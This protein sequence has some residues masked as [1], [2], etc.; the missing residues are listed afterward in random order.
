[1]ASYKPNYLPKFISP[2]FITL[3]VRAS[4]CK[5]GG[6]GSGHKYPLHNNG[7]WDIADICSI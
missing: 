1:M 5:F 4:T 7:V 6:G 3:G 2:D